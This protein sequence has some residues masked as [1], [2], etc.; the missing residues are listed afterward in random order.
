MCEHTLHLF[1]PASHPFQQLGARSGR[2]TVLRCFCR[3]VCIHTQ[4]RCDVPH[5]IMPMLHVSVNKFV[6]CLQLCVACT[7]IGCVCSGVGLTSDRESESVRCGKRRACSYLAVGPFE[8]EYFV[9]FE[10]CSRTQT[11]AQIA[12]AF[13]CLPA[14]IRTRTRQTQTRTKHP[15]LPFSAADAIQQTDSVQKEFNFHHPSRRWVVMCV[16]VSTD[17]WDAMS[18][19]EP[20]IF[21]TIVVVEWHANTDLGPTTTTTAF[22]QRWAS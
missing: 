3:R 4:Q 5:R 21:A 20:R 22:E 12:S 15:S 10:K 17:R 18:A 19:D 9:Q 8:R 16:D 1:S 2:C 7:Y 14:N 6:S 11:R 13:C